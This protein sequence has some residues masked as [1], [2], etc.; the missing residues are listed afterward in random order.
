MFIA[1]QLFQSNTANLLSPSSTVMKLPAAAAAQLLAVIGASGNFTTLSLSNGVVSEIVY[2]TGVSGVNV[3]IQ[4]AQEGSTAQ[5]F[6]AGTL[7]RFVW[8]E[9][10]IQDVASG[11]SAGITITGGGA[12][13][14]TG[15]PFAFNVSTPNVSL[16]AGTGIAISG[17]APNF[18]VTNIAPGGGGG[19]ITTITGSGQAI[20]TPITNGFN[21]NVPTPT[22]S[23][24]TGIGI[25]G[26]WPAVTIT[27]TD[28]GAGA[29]GT[30]TSVT[31]GSGISVTGS[32]TINPTVS[33]SPSGVTAGTYGGI[34]VDVFGRITNIS[35]GLIT[36][37]TSLIPS[38]LVVGTPSLGSVTLTITDASTSAKGIIQRAVNTS[39]A[40]S[41]P[42]DNLTCVTPSGVAAVLAAQ[43][44]VTI[45]SDTANIPLASASYTVPAITSGTALNLASGKTALVTV[46]IEEQDPGAPTSIPSFG[47]GL[48][49]G[50]TFIDGNSDNVPSA[51]RTLTVKITGPFTGV[52][53]ARVTA[54]AGTF[55]IQSKSISV[56]TN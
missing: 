26:T 29:T 18:T 3:T 8:T 22:I 11:G 15:G 23:A 34:V 42:A 55:A 14:V 19:G 24:G 41:D 21:V 10:S 25:T 51:A 27:N 13:T 45:I 32:P 35:T 43:T 12:T 7:V 49:T 50:L 56:V 31:G 40:S 46:G 9:V 2:A 33:L 37:I 38:I 17:S 30:V 36:S 53:S 28:P 6:T 16:T 4:R 47:I 44:P 5:T 54:L 20:V 48:F 39:S 52:L 1:A